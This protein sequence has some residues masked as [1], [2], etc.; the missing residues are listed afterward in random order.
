MTHSN[1]VS[2]HTNGLSESLIPSVASNK[3]RGKKLRNLSIFFSALLGLMTH[4]SI[5]GV[6]VWLRTVVS[7]PFEHRAY[8]TCVSSFLSSTLV[9][10]IYLSLSPLAGQLQSKALTTMGFLCSLVFS[11]TCFDI[12]L[13]RTNE[14]ANPLLVITTSWLRILFCGCLAISVYEKARKT[15]ISKESNFDL[16]NPIA[17][18]MRENMCYA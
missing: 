2:I 12:A 4:L 17:N 13:L 10:L 5:L 11:S 6:D 7:T 15:E 9:V 8:W 3:I 18:R 1:P 16:L 14:L